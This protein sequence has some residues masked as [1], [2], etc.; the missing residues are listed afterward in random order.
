M[1]EHCLI[2][3]HKRADN[4]KHPD[5][6]EKSKK[7]LKGM[8]KLFETKKDNLKDL[9]LFPLFSNAYFV[10]KENLPFTKYTEIKKLLD[11]L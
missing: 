1:S 4:H 2:D 11:F 6:K 9:L 3:Y 8:I 7:D 5:K 10:A